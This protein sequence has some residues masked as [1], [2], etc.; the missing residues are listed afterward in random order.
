MGAKNETHLLTG[1][2][3]LP[4][5]PHPVKYFPVI[6]QEFFPHFSVIPAKKKRPF[7]LCWGKGYEMAA[8]GKIFCPFPIDD[9]IMGTD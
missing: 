2:D 6:F 5:A 1:R 3:S 4:R 7:R 8:R 9:A